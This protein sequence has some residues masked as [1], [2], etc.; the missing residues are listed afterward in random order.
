MLRWQDEPR[1][2]TKLGF[3]GDGQR[4]L[5]RVGFCRRGGAGDL[6]DVSMSTI[7]LFFKALDPRIWLGIA[8]AI[9]VS[10][11]YVYMYHLGG[12]GPR[13]DLAALKQAVEQAQKAYA[14][15]DKRRAEASARLTKSLETQRDETA[16]N[17]VAGWAAYYGVQS[18]SNR[19]GKGTEPVRPAPTICVDPDD[20]QRL[21]DAL[22]SYRAEVRAGLDELFEALRSRRIEVGQLL[23]Q[24]QLQAA[25]AVA[26]KAWA[27]EQHAINAP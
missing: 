13:A 14:A 11:S 7:W 12:N 17:A 22:Q 4:E 20:N 3:L 8:I 16:A 27:V 2:N 15:E 23:E 26:C 21:S 10:T 18:A 19:P 9:A 25:D 5:Y 1:R 6:A 24:A